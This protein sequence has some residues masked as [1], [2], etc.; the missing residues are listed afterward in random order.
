VKEKRVIDKIAGYLEVGLNH[1]GEVV[2]NHPKP[3]DL[4]ADGSGHFV[5]SPDQ[6]RGLA[7]LLLKH[8]AA[9]DAVAGSRKDEAARLAAAAIP[10]DRSARALTDGS[11][12]TP[13]HR[14]INPATGQQKAYVVLTA[15][16]RA[17]GFVRPVRQSYKHL[18]CGTE[19]TMALAI[20]ETYARDPGFYDGTF[21][22]CCGRHFPLDQFVWAGT[23]EPVG[24]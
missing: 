20:A 2:I 22:V 4:E 19:T 24:S 16:E 11:A 23:S 8:A 13:D 21:C 18:G 10:V 3:M 1:A 5:F 17:K 9:A 6:A 15:E 12:E 14:E 7:S